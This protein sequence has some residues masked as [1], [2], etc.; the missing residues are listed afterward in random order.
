MRKLQAIADGL[1]ARFMPSVDAAAGCQSAC[2]PPGQCPA[3][4]CGGRSC[5]IMFNCDVYCGG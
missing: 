1:L 2:Y 3:T 4:V 5:S